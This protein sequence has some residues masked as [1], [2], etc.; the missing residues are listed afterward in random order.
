MLRK[1]SSYFSNFESARQR[2]MNYETGLYTNRI[3]HFPRGIPIAE[4]ERRK[5]IE[6]CI[7][8]EHQ[9]LRS[10]LINDGV[11]RT[12]MYSACISLARVCRW[13]DDKNRLHLLQESVQGAMTIDNKLVRLDALCMIAFYSYSD[14]NQIQV[15][16]EKSLR[17]EI[18]Y[19]LDDIH[20]GLPLLLHA[21]IF[22][23]CLPLLRNE[24]TI[25]L[26]LQ[27]LLV[28]LLMPKKKINKWSMK[29]YHLT[30]K[31]R[32]NVSPVLEKIQV[33][34]KS[35]VLQE[36]FNTATNENLCF[37]LL[38]TNMYLA[39]IANE[40]YEKVTM[41]DLPLLSQFQIKL[42]FNSRT[43]FDYIDCVKWI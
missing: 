15:N 39:E 6:E 25:N 17:N 37:S 13:S 34:N 41:D 22:I 18:E 8:E 42:G 9:R 36:Y 11:T 7:E 20:P 31:S 28:S 35:S 19:Q 38:L 33:N 14:Y 26:C 16:Q 5:L 43:S 4:E 3:E 30:F 27:N 1:I 21:A 24:E 12:N 23:R 32:F 29:H 10:A 40:F 2:P